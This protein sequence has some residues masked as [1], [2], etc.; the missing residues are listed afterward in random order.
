M[1]QCSWYSSA[2]PQEFDALEPRIEAAESA[3]TDIE[4]QLAQPDVWAG[5]GLRGRQL[6]ESLEESRRT[7]ETL[8]Q[9]WE[10]LAERAEL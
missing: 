6:N 2:H 7:L 1:K 4:A 3:L 9:R 10:E 5:D 8:M